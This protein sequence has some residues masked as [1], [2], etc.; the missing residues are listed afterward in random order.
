[1]HEL[2]SLHG[3]LGQEVS[4][5]LLGSL[6]LP[7][8]PDR[9]MVHLRCVSMHVPEFLDI[10]AH[11]YEGPVEVHQFYLLAVILRPT[12]LARQL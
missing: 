8:P 11:F 4:S 1:M 10:F 7:R 5:S 3:H 2:S 6:S 9:F 12:F